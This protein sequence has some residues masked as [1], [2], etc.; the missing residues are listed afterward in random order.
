MTRLLK[1]TRRFFETGKIIIRRIVSVI[2]VCIR[3]VCPRVLKSILIIQ[4][5]KIKTKRT[6]LSKTLPKLSFWARKLTGGGTDEV[7]TGGTGP[8]DCIDVWYWT[9]LVVDGGEKLFGLKNVGESKFLAFGKS[10][11][12]SISS[13]LW[14]KSELLIGPE[15]F[16]GFKNI[17]SVPLSSL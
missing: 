11:K 2:V 12:K 14:S 16:G 15:F 10:G 3:T 17:E 8:C 6:S 1:L 7:W 9:V 13:G 4:I 5:L